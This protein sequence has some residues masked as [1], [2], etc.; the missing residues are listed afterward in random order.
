[1]EKRLK[2]LPTGIQTFEKIVEDGCIYVDK[3]QMLISLVEKGSV[4]FLAR[5]RRFGKSLTLTTL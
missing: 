4:Y 1:M 2:K 5:P 3:T